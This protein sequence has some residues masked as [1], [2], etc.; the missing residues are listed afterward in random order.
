MGRGERLFV[1]YAG[2][3]RAWAEWVAWHLQDAGYDVELDLWH[4]GAGDN[5][6]LRMSQAVERGRMVALSS[7]RISRRPGSQ[8]RSGHRGWP[9]E[10]A[11]SVRC[12]SAGSAFPGSNPGAA[13]GR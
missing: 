5:A 4:W 9:R 6:V 3:D 11:T 1:S 13:T 10:M 8:P 12:K 7:R 2:A